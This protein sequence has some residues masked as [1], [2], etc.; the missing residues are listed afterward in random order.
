MATSWLDTDFG[1]GGTA[2]AEPPK[3]WLDTDFSDNAPAMPA[4][5]STA[6]IDQSLG[7]P[8]Q[9]AEQPQWNP[10]GGDTYL[11][12][13][14]QIPA[15]DA[16]NAIN[17]QAYGQ[18]AL[19]N[20]AIAARGVERGGVKLVGGVGN[21]ALTATKESLSPEREKPSVDE[22]NTL[23]ERL[24]R[25]KAAGASPDWIAANEQ[26]LSDLKQTL[27][28]WGDKPEYPQQQRMADAQ[29]AVASTRDQFNSAISNAAKSLSAGD[30]EVPG[31]KAI[32]DAVANVTELGGSM[33]LPGGFL[34]YMTAN[35]VA[36]QLAE[37]DKNKITGPAKYGAAAAHGAIDFFSALAG[38]KLLGAGAEKLA[39]LGAAGGQDVAGKV[40]QWITEK[41][42]IGGA[43]GEL[44]AKATTEAGAQAVLGVGTTISHYMADV[45][46]GKHDF[47]SGQLYDQLKE[48][49]PTDLL[50]GGFASGIHGII[51]TLG[52]RHAAAQ[53]VAE[54]AGVA[55]NAPAQGDQQA[56]QFGD[57][58]TQK[59]GAQDQQAET[60]QQFAPNYGDAIQPEAH[61]AIP[62]APEATDAVNRLID[63]FNSGGTISRR[64]LARAGIDSSKTTVDVRR[65]IAKLLA[66]S[67]EQRSFV[68]SQPPTPGSEVIPNGSQE[69]TGQGQQEAEG[70][71]QRQQDA[72][73][74]VGQDVQ[75]QQQEL[76]A[77]IEPAGPTEA[78]V[79]PSPPSTPAGQPVSANDKVNAGIEKMR[80]RLLLEAR[81]QD[82]SDM[83]D[84]LDEQ[85]VKPKS[86][87]DKFFDE[88]YDKLPP[89]EQAFFQK[90]LKAY[91]GAEPGDLSHIDREGN[92][93]D[94]KDWKDIGKQLFSDYGSFESIG[95]DG[96]DKPL[97]MLIGR[98]GFL[99]RNPGADAREMLG[100][101]RSGLVKPAADA[102]GPF[103]TVG[104]AN[105][106][107]DRTGGVI[108][109]LRNPPPGEPLTAADAKAAEELQGEYDKHLA[110]LQSHAK[111]KG[112]DL[113]DPN[114]DLS[115]LTYA[116]IERHGAAEKPAQTTKIGLTKK[117][118]A[119]IQ[120][121][122][123]EAVAPSKRRSG[124]LRKTAVDA[125]N[126]AFHASSENAPEEPV[127]YRPIEQDL[128]T[129]DKLADENK[130]PRET[131]D[132]L[133][134]LASSR[135]ADLQG[136]LTEAA[137]RRDVA[138]KEVE[139]LRTEYKTMISGKDSRS[140]SFQANIANRRGGDM[141][142][143][144]GFDVL[145]DRLRSG[146][147]PQ[148]AALAQQRG[149]GDLESGLADIMRGGLK[150]FVDVPE[151]HAIAD[152]TA[153][154]MRHINGQ[155]S[156]SEAPPEDFSL[157]RAPAT[158]AQPD[159]FESTKTAQPNLI[160]DLQRGNLP[161]QK[162]IF[163]EEEFPPAQQSKA[164]VLGFGG[165]AERRTADKPETAATPE[166]Q[167]KVVAT[168]TPGLAIG[169]GLKSKTQGI[170]SL[171]L[172][173][174]NS[175]EHLR[176][177]EHLGAEIGS[178]NRRQESSS[179]EL[180]P[181]SKEFN[182]LGLDRADVDPA[183]N[184]G[185]KFMSAIST[186][187][188]LTGWMQKA[189]TAIQKGFSDRLE[190]LA[191]AGEPL[192]ATREHYFPGLWTQES[193]LA[194]NAAVGDAV[195]AEVIP[196]GS[197]LNHA[198]PKQVDWI[199]ARVDEHLGAGTGSDKDALPYLTK[200]PLA[201]G[202]SFKKAKVFDDTMTA[203]RLG[204][205]PISNN[206]IDL[207]N[208]KNAEMDRSIMAHTFFQKRAKDGQLKII[209]PYE[210]TPDG[211]VK[212]PDRYGTV[213]GPP[214]VTVEEHI[215]R[216][217]YD[218]L[219]NV[220]KGLGVT[221]ERLM[222]LP[223]R[224]AL[225][226]SYQGGDKIQ[227]K[228]ATETSVLA[229]ELGH[230]LDVKYDLWNT[231]LRTKGGEGK[232]FQKGRSELRAIADLTERGAVARSRP[233]KIA[234]VLEAYIHTPEKMQEVAPRIYKWFDNFVK[235]KPG[236]AG[237]AD[238][239]PGLATKKLTSEKY[240]GLPIVGYRVVP[241]AVGDVLNNY[242]SSNLYNNRYFGGLYKGWM[243]AANSLN[244][245]Q[246]GMGSAFHAGFT[247]GE[248]QVS[249]HA[250]L[251]KDIYGVVRGS[252]NVSDLTTSLGRSATA[253]V[254]TPMLGDKV[255][256]AWR[257]P[258]GQ[259]DP[260][261][262]QVVKA[263][264]LAGGGFTMERGLRT[265]QTEKMARDW[266]SGRPL[267]AAARSPVAFTEALSKPIMDW[268]VPRQKAG[269]FADLA[270]RIIDQNPGKSLE[271]LTPEFRQ[272]WNR[273][274]ARLG[275]VR[276]DRLF[277]N[278]AAKNVIQGLVR[279]PGW[280]G[281]TVAEIGGAFPDAAKF[282]AEFAKT[283]KLPKELPDRVAHALALV[284]TVAAVNGA[285]T[286][287]FTGQRPQGMDYFAFRDGGKDEYGNDTRWLLPTYMRDLV[288]YWQSSGQ[289]LL[290]GTSPLI[291]MVSE[292]KQNRDYYGTEIRHPGD[293][294]YK[295]GADVGKYVAKSYE[296]FW[297]RNLQQAQKDD[298]GAGEKISTYFGVTPA[299][300]RITET[301]AER[302]AQDLAGS[303]MPAA[304]RTQQESDRSELKRSLTKKVAASGQAAAAPEI[305]QATRSGLLKP[306][307]AKAIIQN[308]GKAPLQRTLKN[309]PAEDAMKVYRVATPE[310]KASIYA[311][312]YAKIHRSTNLGDEDKRRFLEEL[313]PR[314]TK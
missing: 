125:A 177:A 304:A 156:A 298:A 65:A 192:E 190:L 82:L 49:L 171:L 24:D 67:A 305:Q 278:N 232:G 113:R 161:G 253:M 248:S 196:E 80:D 53:E 155:P 140:H 16:Q 41:Y 25:A 290:N 101:P 73:Q 111:E 285:L 165:R 205:R 90:K 147:Y 234:Q 10:E 181:F 84:T 137:K 145:V 64:D 56:Q 301:D 252:R 44:A 206:P 23:S 8:Q 294:L 93:F 243:G 99:N 169:T 207:V 60:P 199:K 52:K 257:E 11:A 148:M 209:T 22:I 129:V 114:A 5:H 182:K 219:L 220:A 132:D 302:T 208:L 300:R 50:T 245:S 130:L 108:D 4:S 107:F 227:S 247:A 175:P 266:Y 295:Q 29:Q 141:A 28:N 35:S 162:S 48:Q 273:V 37:A 17:D 39:G 244:Q 98:M 163:D 265:D 7:T 160:P 63:K 201:G 174:M 228:F 191:K 274:D 229:H 216:D 94:Y 251:I 293:P 106:W 222:K 36:N 75:G 1:G 72:E 154:A 203:Q 221:H 288:S 34:G 96:W 186:G 3:S 210:K 246:L 194:F 166:E 26:H 287:A 168:H 81:G 76:L 117:R 51:E 185:A 241:Q 14:S 218:G 131:L 19:A 255:L 122:A 66:D 152:V 260:K 139:D 250:N 58:V 32:G 236:L 43:V 173:S 128:A 118:T 159:K 183:D 238:I 103:D 164:A 153:E 303:Q 46:A 79:E 217:V 74:N 88:T 167:A 193:R 134:F 224:G 231:L 54:K 275:Q 83:L 309:L 15:A 213:Y 223:R 270:S 85:G 178:M 214:T 267:R 102:G 142:K 296:P 187:G 149:Q 312:V 239:K 200:R 126:E 276:Y 146:D 284:G 86:V 184:A 115:D 212:V 176:A 13:A 38:G 310:E 235:S 105:Y 211:W 9:V 172:P 121:P 256:N 197:D 292:L 61:P 12:G 68:Q 138:Q 268:I 91:A 30:T 306:S 57:E 280:K 87:V 198:T 157:E 254:R 112:I 279:A 242:L 136:V 259:I 89:A 20:P 261:I 127:G 2:V 42:P 150:Q 202:E 158:V 291:S 133:D 55:S 97:K 272:A 269:V 189:A 215:D 100:G 123:A 226:L 92:Q 277:T 31:G 311:T 170:T 95:Q 143:V 249:A 77:P 180:R 120:Q 195:K 313:G 33:A 188:S 281:G 240:V 283:G 314:P 135:P 71:Q 264:E 225:G 62:P 286:L 299:T 144:K 47:D 262:A 204:L 258:E 289:T 233:E 110:A 40:A 21:A 119:E 27:D 230:Q 69:Q 151:D 308:A 297:L 45:A 179:H 124:L 78:A 104:E 282:V 116:K 59:L 109:G 307:D 70:Q 6:T 263:A 18:Y 271:E 237:L